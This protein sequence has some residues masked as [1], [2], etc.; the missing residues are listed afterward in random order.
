MLIRFGARSEGRV[1]AVDWPL[2]ARRAALGV[3]AVEVVAELATLGLDSLWTG[4]PCD[5][6]EGA[7]P[8]VE[9]ASDWPKAGRGSVRPSHAQNKNA[10]P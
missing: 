5:S 6:F 8:M 10:M 2:E 3:M 7:F 1:G 9:D 4:R